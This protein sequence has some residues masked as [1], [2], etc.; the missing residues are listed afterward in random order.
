M[1]ALEMRKCP[2]CKELFKVTEQRCPFCNHVE[3]QAERAKRIQEKETQ[4]EAEAQALEMRKKKFAVKRMILKIMLIISVC[5]ILCTFLFEDYAIFLVI[6][7]IISVIFSLTIKCPYCGSIL[8]RA[9][10]LGILGVFS[11]DCPTCRM[12]LH[13]EKSVYGE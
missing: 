13:K 6:P 3:S 9:P 11:S 12:Q 2:K 5:S 4:K 1:G 10:F 7:I 8:F